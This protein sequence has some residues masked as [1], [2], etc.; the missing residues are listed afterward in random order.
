MEFLPIV[1]R[2]EYCGDF[3][4]CIAFNDGVESTIDFSDWLTGPIF[5][6]GRT[7]PTLRRKPSTSEPSLARPPDADLGPRAATPSSA[8]WVS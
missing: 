1:I 3:T 5:E 2:A 6:R 7:A 4:I 8:S